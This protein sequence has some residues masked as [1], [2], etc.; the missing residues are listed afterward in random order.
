MSHVR[1]NMNRTTKKVLI[2]TMTLALVFGFL[3]LFIPGHNF[4]RLHIFLFNLCSGGTFILIYTEQKNHFS[5]KTAAFYI[6]SVLYAVFAFFQLY[7]YAIVIAVILALLVETIRSERFSFVPVDFFKGSV[8]VSA[9]FHQA[10]LLCLS[11]GLII[12][13]LVMGNH[14]YWRIVS[15]PKLTLDIFFLGFS[16]PVSLITMSVMFGMMDKTGGRWAR[17]LKEYSFWA[18]NLGVI[19]FFLFIILGLILAELA[20]ALV[21]FI[22]VVIVFILY[23][24]LGASRQAKAFLTSGAVFLIMTAITGIAYI[25]LYAVIPQPPGGKLLLKLHALISLYGWNLNGLAVI[26]RYEDFPIRLNSS[27]IILLHWIV[28]VILA[29]LGF[30]YRVLAVAAVAAYAIFLYLVFFTRSFSAP[31]GNN[32]A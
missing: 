27:R 12:S 17:L 6:M 20:I 10:S 8:P 19:V 7:M 13:S 3:H 22:T 15:S 16:F 30:Y 31:T 9:K 4:E 32:P 28:V 24:R 11:L 21:L 2:I 5:L 29:P 26:S 18:V 23:A 1:Y 25:I 14:E